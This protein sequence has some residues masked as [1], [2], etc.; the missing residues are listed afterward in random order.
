MTFNAWSIIIH[1]VR[2]TRKSDKGNKHFPRFNDNK[3]RLVRPTNQYVLRIVVTARLLVAEDI[4]PST[5]K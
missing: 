4:F 2:E 3:P 1:K 5:L